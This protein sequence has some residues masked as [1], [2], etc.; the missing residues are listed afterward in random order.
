M[1]HQGTLYLKCSLWN[2]I[3]SLS[4]SPSLTIFCLFVVICCNIDVTIVVVHTFFVLLFSSYLLLLLRSG[5][6]YIYIYSNIPPRPTIYHHM[7]RT[8]M[9][10]SSWLT[11]LFVHSFILPV[12]SVVCVEYL[13]LT[14]SLCVCV[15]HLVHLFSVI[16]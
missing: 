10:F 6:K 11:Y 7:N 9:P 4:I 1:F 14:L 16:V 5:N 2:L 13:S 8:I 12:I 15:F 3:V